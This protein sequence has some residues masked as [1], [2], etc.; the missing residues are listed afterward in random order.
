MSE[1]NYREYRVIFVDD[2]PEQLEAFSLNFRRQFDLK[3]AASGARTG[4]STT[5]RADDSIIIP[6]TKRKTLTTKRKRT[7]LDVTDIGRQWVDEEGRH[8][9]VMVAGRHT[10]ELVL[11]QDNL[12]WRVVRAPNDFAAA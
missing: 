5:S 4:V 11:A 7:W 8:V 2:E 1:R 3:L 10:F 12:S 9:L 6:S